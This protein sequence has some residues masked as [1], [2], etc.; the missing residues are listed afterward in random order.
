MYGY[1]RVHVIIFGFLLK[2]IVLQADLAQM[3]L[4]E[5]YNLLGLRQDQHLAYAK[6]QMTDIGPESE[7]P[8]L[9]LINRWS[10]NNVQ[11]HLTAL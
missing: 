11:D 4:A 2:W 1:C 6:G 9:S 8:H 7:S 3:V 5:E 10:G